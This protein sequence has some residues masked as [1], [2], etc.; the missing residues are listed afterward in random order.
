MLASSAARHAEAAANNTANVNKQ[1]ILFMESPNA[2]FLRLK[3]ED[4]GDEWPQLDPSGT[5]DSTV[6]P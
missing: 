5:N 3:Q 1:I 2:I 4:F 6:T